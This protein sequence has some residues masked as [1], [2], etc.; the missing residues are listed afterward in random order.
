MYLIFDTETTGLPKDYNAPVS[1][2]DNW[3]R[4]VQ[5]AWQLH[6]KNGELIE[7]KDFIIRPE[8]FQIPYE[9][10]KIH[11]ISQQLAELKGVPVREVLEHFNR[12]IEKTQFIVG[13]NIRFDLNIMGA[14]FL[15]AGI[16]SQLLEKPV[17]DTCTETTAGLCRIPGGRKGKYKLPTL[18]E[19]HTHLF[20]ESFEEAHNAT[21]DVEATAR[22]FFEL[23]RQR[24]YTTGELGVEEAYF[25]EFT[26]K[27]PGPIRPAGIPHL[28]LKA[29]SAAL[30]QKTSG[31][32]T[33]PG[34]IP[35]VLKD[36][37]FVHL[38]NHTQYSVLNSTSRIKDLVQT[39]VDMGMPAV[40]LTDTGNM[41]GAYEFYHHIRSANRKDWETI[42]PI[43]GC[44]LDI[45]ADMGVKNPK[46]RTAKIVLLAKDIHAYKNLIKLT[47]L[48]QTEGFYFVPRI[49]KKTLL[50]HREGLIVL[51]GGIDGIIAQKIL[52]AHEKEWDEEVSWWKEHFGEDFYLE[53]VRHGLEE[54][55]FVNTKLL[56][57]AGK[58][59]IKPVATNNTFF[60][61]REDAEAQRI[62]LKVKN[63]NFR[64]FRRRPDEEPD[65]RYFKSQDE[66][67][68]LFA[69][70]PEAIL[71]TGEIA[72][73]IKPFSLHRPV[74]LPKFNIP[75]AFKDP[76][77]EEDGGSRG[78][79]AYLR[80]L[81]YQ[82]AKER[83]GEITPEIEERLEFELN[84]INDAGFA[85][86]FLIVWDVIYQARK[87]GVSVGPGR[88]SA[89]GSAVAYCLKIT[90][91]DPIKYGLLFERF[92][93]LERISLPDIDIDFDDERRERVL[94]YVTA[95]YGKE[96]T[97]QIIT[98]GTMGAKSAFRDAA[99]VMGADPQDVNRVAKFIPD[100]MKLEVLLNPEKYPDII[101]ELRDDDKKKIKGLHE[102]LQNEPSY[103]K[104]FENALKVEGSL[105]NTGVHACGFIISP[106]PVDSI[107]PIARAKD[108]DIPV[109]Q[110]NQDFVES[111]GLLKM[112]FLGLKTLTLIRKTL[113]IIKAIHGE[114][115]DMDNVN[116]EDEETLKLFQRGD[117]VGVFQFESEGIRKALKV[118]KPNRFTDIIAVVALY[119]PGPMEYIPLYANRKHGKVPIE[120]P[121]PE[122][123]EYLKETYGVTV[124]QEQ[125]MLLSQKLAG[126]SK[127]EADGL[128]KAM[129]K[130]II[131]KL[132]E[133]RPKFFEGAKQRGHPE[134]VLEKIWKDWEKFTSYAFNKSHAT[135]YAFIAF[136]T[137]FLKA[138]YPPEYMASVLTVNIHDIKKVGFYMEEC[139]RMGIEVLGPDVNES[140][141]HFSVNKKRQIRFGMGGIK[142]V[143]E[144]AVSGIIEERKKNGPF[145]GI[146]DFVR[147]SD[148]RQVNKRVMEGLAVAGAFDHF[149]IPRESYFA[150]DDKGKSFID[151]LLY[152]GHRHQEAESSIQMS[153]FGETTGAGELE[154]PLPPEA[155]EWSIME[156][157]SRE[158]EAVG[159]YISAHPLDTY[160]YEIENFCKMTISELQDLSKW[161][162]KEITFAGIVT[163]AQH[164]QTKYSKGYAIITLEDFTGDITIRVFGDAYIKY[165][166]Y[167]RVNN[168]LYVKAK[169]IKGRNEG[170]MRLIYYDISS[171][172]ELLEK[173]GKTITLTFDI[174][175]LNTGILEELEEMFKKYK[176]DKA[177]QFIVMDPDERVSVK[178]TGRKRKVHISTELIEF[179]KEKQWNFELN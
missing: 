6:D 81:T 96:N 3:P 148:L 118:I 92:L 14:E 64:A 49:D 78:E 135:V 73:K 175:E 119:R 159:M 116:L 56:E 179:L 2:L 59:G 129:G 50:E 82:G 131:K 44:E 91:L 67:K 17:L 25:D 126:F 26:A 146:Y 4:C 87:M 123:E 75:D 5:I 90:N 162:G 168:F 72:D 74:E 62:L 39:A 29:E 122:M 21:A 121:L 71:N 165:N 65:T 172:T 115:I 33:Q 139:R 164:R 68:E 10:R 79:Q 155:P 19:L 101:G 42:K 35:G 120:Y 117:T 108:S 46:E 43:I 161:E 152:Y 52:T 63:E 113:E 138:H 27:H 102:I 134:E 147:R 37:T 110:F 100:R 61:H 45:T 38:H 124:Y 47:S 177:V 51:S 77:D 76:K 105:R 15:R 127:A 141:Y 66:M 145:T 163:D 143:G 93:N 169:V 85:G 54:E 13:Q 22:C 149:G 104:V 30:E 171:L 178:L 158:K 48:A 166:N 136:Q 20:G 53:I 34:G 40:A 153:L 137:G 154:E 130:K 88:G 144:A 9:V 36:T 174:N 8:G 16:E 58:H 70:I 107:I 23:V 114:E 80:H 12:A 142:G 24:V 95:K 170:E 57:L 97:A 41:M 60:I 18:T 55:N 128:R 83:W 157:L 173:K 84:I 160:Q 176:G 1:D 111:A 32:P 86:Y 99:R 125:V 156:K 112:D 103:K 151:T 133:L 106:A 150:T 98:Y 94:Q 109:T 31:Q 7:H 69:D 89:A 28:D 11:G 132:E 140:Y 167:F